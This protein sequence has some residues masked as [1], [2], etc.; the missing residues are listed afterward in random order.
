MQKVKICKKCKSKEQGNF[1]GYWP[2]L[3]DD[4]YTCMNCGGT[5]EDIDFDSNDFFTLWQASN[6]I[7]FIDAM[8]DLHEKDPIEYGIKMSQIQNQVNQQKAI[9]NQTDNTPKCPT[10]GSR[11]IEKISA[12]SKAIGAGL[13]GIFSKTAR[14]QFKCKSCGYKW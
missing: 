9:Q 8:I 13:F 7:K 14:C 1:K 11:N 5:I 10:C 4:Y 2:F 12:T 3:K 6:D